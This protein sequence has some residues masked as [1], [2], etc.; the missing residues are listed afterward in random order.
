[1]AAGFL[2]VC[3]PPPA[4]PAPAGGGPPAAPPPPGRPRP[5]PPP[6]PPV[7]APAVDAATIAELNAQIEAIR[8]ALDR[9]QQQVEGLPRPGG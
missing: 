3:A 5:A 2:L 1:M 4:T 7:P 9:I 6:G 8:D